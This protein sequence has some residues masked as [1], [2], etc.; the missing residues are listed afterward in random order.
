MCDAYYAVGVFAVMDECNALDEARR[1]ISWVSYFNALR[2]SK[3]K[4]PSAGGFVNGRVV[5]HK[6]HGSSSR[7]LTFDCQGRQHLT[8]KAQI[9]Y[10]LEAGGVHASETRVKVLSVLGHLTERPAFQLSSLTKTSEGLFLVLK[11]QNKAV[12]EP[13][14]V[15]PQVHKA[16]A[17]RGS[18][19]PV[20]GSARFSSPEASVRNPL[21]FGHVVT[22][23]EDEIV[24]VWSAAE[25]ASL[26]EGELAVVPTS[27]VPPRFCWV[28]RSLN[29]VPGEIGNA[30]CVG[31]VGVADVRST[32]GRDH[33][34]DA[35]PRV[36][37]SRLTR[38]APGTPSAAHV[39]GAP[40]TV[41]QP[42]GELT[43]LQV[44]ETV[45]HVAEVSLNAAFSIVN[46]TTSTTDSGA[47]PVSLAFLVRPPTALAV[48]L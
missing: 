9:E 48:S 42:F 44:L 40:S 45:I 34:L 16:M 28:G 7:S 3:L 18:H 12:L 32:I 2:R 8:G 41:P 4:N 27:L 10:T 13:L 37:N 6:S 11:A 19:P 43:V 17:R 33:A 26:Y 14:S 36:G 22:C 1:L 15:L 47:H 30:A 46:T 39:E 23:K 21:P 25:V 35:F 38:G 20:D 5:N 31:P 24:V 29:F